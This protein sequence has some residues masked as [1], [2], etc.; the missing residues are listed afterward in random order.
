LLLFS[1]FINRE[2][3]SRQS[4]GF[5]NGGAQMKAQNKFAKLAFLVIAGS[6]L[7]TLSTLATAESDAVRAIYVSAASVPT[8]IPGIHTYAEPPKGFNP[9]TATDAQLAAYGFPPRPDKQADPDHYVLWERAMRAARIRWNGELKPLPGGGH[10]MIPAGSSLRPDAVQPQTTTTG[11]M[12]ISTINASGVILQNKQTSWSNTKSFNLVWSYI[13]VPTAQIPMGTSPTQYELGIFEYSMVGIDGFFSNGQVEGSNP[14]F[15]PG[16]FGGL[17]EAPGYYYAVYG[18]GGLGGYID[19]SLETFAVNPGDEF[20]ALVNA[21]ANSGATDGY[22]FLEDSTNGN[23]ESYFVGTPGPGD[24]STVQLVGQS[25]EWMVLRGCCNG[26]SLY[27]TW[28]L[29]NTFSIAFNYGGATTGN[30]KSF[31][32]GSQAKSTEILTMTD[33]LGDQDIEV[34]NQGS[35]GYQGLHSLWFETFNCA[36]AGGCTP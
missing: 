17:Y 30:G 28:P 15:W 34:V 31:Y 19:G 20:Y 32:P 14:E 33:D 8:N 12:Q 9:V 29:P 21:Y 4:P 35:S 36:Y 1:D 10:G 16:L 26:P 7:L 27:G 18:Y 13:T 2:R 23:Y 22:V 3:N 11:P 24:G 6:L 25:A 5:K